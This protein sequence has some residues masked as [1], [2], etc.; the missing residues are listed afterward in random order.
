MRAMLTHW[1]LVL[2]LFIS[3]QS[4]NFGQEPMRQWSSRDNRQ[5]VEASFQSYD[6]EAKQVTLQ[7]QNGES[8]VVDLNELGRSDQRYVK[9]ARNRLGT[10]DDAQSKGVIKKEVTPARPKHRDSSK[11]TT[12]YGIHWTPGIE[13]ALSNAT[14]SESSEDDRPVMWLR[15]L[16][17]LNGFM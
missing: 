1:G 8:L 4:E 5:S 14:G 12:A 6:P 11:V 17:D 2:I 9:S 16:G 15:V 10:V 13:N 3:F 7:L